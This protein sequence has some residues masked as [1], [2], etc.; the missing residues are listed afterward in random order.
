MK[1]NQS[2][3]KNMRKNNELRSIKDDTRQV[4]QKSIRKT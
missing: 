3:I 4:F 1:K 2:E